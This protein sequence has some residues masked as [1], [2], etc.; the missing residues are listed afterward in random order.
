VQGLPKFHAIAGI[1]DSLIFTE[2]LIIQSVFAIIAEYSFWFSG[3]FEVKF[4]NAIKSFKSQKHINITTLKEGVDTAFNNTSNKEDSAWLI[5]WVID[6][7]LVSSIIL[8]FLY[9]L[10]ICQSEGQIV[11][12]FQ[13]IKKS[14][15]G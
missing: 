6:N 14:N 8:H 4:F 10:L 3:K 5:Q 12:L 1:T 9:K 15:Y 13:S 11:I 2:Y 7:K